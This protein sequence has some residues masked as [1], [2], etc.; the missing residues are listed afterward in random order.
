MML[1][2]MTASNRKQIQDC[3]WRRGNHLEI[4]PPRGCHA[5]VTK[6]NYKIVKMNMINMNRIGSGLYQD[7]SEDYGFPRHYISYLVDS[8]SETSG[9]QLGPD[10]QRFVCV[11][12][13]KHYKYECSLRRHLKFECGHLPKFTCWKCGYS[14]KRHHNLLRHIKTSKHLN[15]LEANVPRGQFQ[16]S[17]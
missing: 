11:R 3:L 8:G 12:C 14:T 15:L 5:C 13:N 1:H 7:A 6:E 10:G 16:T 4:Q 2:S 17:E 9:S